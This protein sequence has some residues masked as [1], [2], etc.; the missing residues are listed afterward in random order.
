MKEESFFEKN[1]AHTSHTLV[2]GGGGGVIFI[3]IFR[4]SNI[5][6]KKIHNNVY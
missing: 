3:Y 2:V 5:M 6:D 4:I 1:L